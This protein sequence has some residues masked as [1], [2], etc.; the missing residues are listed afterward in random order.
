MKGKGKFEDKKWLFL[1]SAILLA[2]V[3]IA[4]IL[5]LPIKSND[6]INGGSFNAA[7][8]S[9]GTE[10]TIKREAPTGTYKSF[11]AV[12][13]SNPIKLGVRA[14]V[15]GQGTNGTYYAENSAIMIFRTSDGTIVYCIELGNPSAIEKNN[16]R[17]TSTSST[18]WTNLGAT[19]QENIGLVTLYGYPN[20][21]R[22][23]YSEIEQYAAAQILIWEFQQG[24]RTNFENVPSNKEIYNRWISKST[25]IK[26]V[27]E[28]ILSD[29]RNR[30]KMPSF[31]GKSLELKYNSSTKKYEGSITDS[32]GVLSMISESC[33]S[34]VQCTK[35]GNTLKITSSNELTYT[36]KIELTKV[37]PNGISQGLLILDNGSNQR[38]IIGKANVTP[39][40]GE[41][42]V[43]TE[44]QKKLGSLTIIKETEDNASGTFKFL[45]TS[46]LGL[47][48]KNI[49]ITTVNGK[50]QIT[51]NDLNPGEYTITELSFPD[52]YARQII[53]T[54]ALVGTQP[55]SITIKNYLKNAGAVTVNKVDEN[56][57]HVKGASM[58]LKNW[59]GVT[60]E[61][62][63]SDGTPKVIKE[64]SANK[65]YKVCEEK[66]PNGYKLNEKCEEFKLESK[67]DSA[68]INFVNRK[69]ELVIKKLDENGKNL[70][71]A[72]LQIKDSNGK[73]V[74]E[75]WETKS[76]SNRMI[77]GLIAGQKYTVEELSAPDGYVKAQNQTFT[78]G[79]V[80][81][82]IITNEKT[83]LLISKQDATTGKEIGGAHL[84]VINEAGSI[85]D[86]WVSEEGKTHSIRGLVLGKKY[87]LKETIA[88]NGYFVSSSIK[89]VF[90]KNKLKVVMKDD[91]SYVV[92]SK[93][94]ATT[95]EEIAGAQLEIIDKTG[96]VVEKW[97]SEKGKSHSVKSLINGETYTLRETLAPTGYFTTTEEIS[98]VA[99]ETKKVVMKNKLT[100]VVV[101]K[102]DTVTKKRV[103][104]A[105][106]QLLDD[107]N[108]VIQEWDTT[109][110]DRVI[111]GLLTGK[112]YSIK[113]TKVPKNYLQSEVITFTLNPK[114]KTIE[115]VVNNTPIVY[116]EDTA[117][118]ANIIMVIVGAVVVLSGVG[119]ILW[120]KKRSA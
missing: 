78:A 101:K 31:V 120:I 88:P 72:I 34:T 109:D 100:E 108:N 86:E 83:E 36:N 35:S 27:Y 19:K 58:V 79:S 46:I 98:F 77:E 40:K 110:K 50:G 84:Q 16:K 91:P 99:G 80:S 23:G 104:G 7:V 75:K 103:T 82:V 111:T 10:V 64:L 9:S 49:E 14:T 61:K 85:V 102:L 29:I 114:G 38:M 119:T 116:V 94:D 76:D 95:G 106:L 60:V 112:Q 56:G 69:S 81:E 44:E 11:F 45:V 67:T 25:K 37:N 57:A 93:Q 73:I 30:S 47:Y 32:N 48:A 97:T 3:V 13:K 6:G 51:L 52:R 74:V 53:P 5:N 1:G 113:E 4:V 117:E 63:T 107:K 24:W 43:T 42:K 55:T 2:T 70:S 54:V 22:S 26:E 115:V 59:L 39:L 18:F 12:P 21:V 33:P 87:T 28:S 62:W 96:K 66:A 118:N 89:F 20:K 68:V 17:P 15:P 41:L 90:D 65:T 105:H 71:W 92:I 8:I